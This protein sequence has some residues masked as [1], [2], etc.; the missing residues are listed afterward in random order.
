MN[1]IKHPATI[2][3]LQTI[4]SMKQRIKDKHPQT[5][6]AL[7]K[8]DG[9]TPSTHTC[10]PVNK[11]CVM[12]NGDKQGEEIALNDGP[13]AYRYILKYIL[14]G[15][16]QF[17]EKAID[18]INKWIDVCT[19]CTGDNAQLSSSWSQVNFARSLELLL[20]LNKSDK[21]DKSNKL[22][23]MKER[24]IKWY[25]KVMLPAI[26]KPITWKFQTKQGYDTYT[27]WHCA[28]LEAR[29]QVALLKD[30]VKGVNECFDLYK[31]ILVEIIETPFNLCNETIYRDVMHG[32][33]SL[34]SLVNIAEMAWHQ[35]CDL[36]SYNNNLLKNAIEATAAICDGKIPAGLPVQSLNKVQYW[37]YAWYIAYN[38]YVNRCKQ[39]M[40]NTSKLITK[41]PVDY[42]WLFSSSCALTHG[43]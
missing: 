2:I 24:Y 41:Y 4:E 6:K 38:H 16:S 30:D 21:S 18:I 1:V 35:G 8:L 37:P 13:M 11:I 29:L 23:R 20:F 34:G 14:T 15:E 17:A 25:D 5:L 33:M 22:E 40:P 19:E 3:S 7:A 39:A 43:F 31:R 27:N 28:I 9:E 36:Y 32:C 42:S 12:W 26:N 10:K